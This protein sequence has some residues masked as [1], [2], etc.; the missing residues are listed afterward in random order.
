MFQELNT[1]ENINL[2]TYKFQNNVR[3]IKKAVLRGTMKR[4]RQLGSVSGLRMDFFEELSL[5]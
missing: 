3:N 1:V 5:K 4:E 2:C